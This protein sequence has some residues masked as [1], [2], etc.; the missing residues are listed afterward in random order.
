MDGIKERRLL[1][2]NNFRGLD[3]ENNPT[4]VELYRA[5]SGENFMIDSNMLKT[6]P[7]IK[8][9]FY[10]NFALEEDETLI[11]YYEYRGIKIF[12]T[13][14]HFYFDNG[15][16]VVNEQS[17]KQINGVN[18]FIKGPGLDSINFSNCVPLFQEEK[19]ALFIFCL[20]D[21]YVFS[22]FLDDNSVI[23]HYVLYDFRY[24]ISVLNYES[25]ETQYKTLLLELPFPYEPTLFIGTKVL[26]DVNLLSPVSK[27]RIFA[28][29]GYNLQEKTK[30]YFL[31][32]NYQ[33]DK[34]SSFSSEVI[35]YKDLFTDYG[36][37]PVFLGIV[38]EH[39]SALFQSDVEYTS[40]AAN[41]ENIFYP[42]QSFEYYAL[43]EGETE[44]IVIH[45]KTGLT[46]TDFFEMNVD[47]TTNKTVFEYMMGIIN[48]KNGFADDNA[49]PTNL[50][51]KFS[52]KIN[53]NCIYRDKTTYS[54]VSNI[55]EELTFNVYVQIK[56]YDK[57]SASFNNDYD[58]QSGSAWTVTNLSDSYPDYPP[59]PPP[60]E[61]K[62]YIPI[63]L[64]SIPID[65]SK[66]IIHNQT[67]VPDRV[68]SNVLFNDMTLEYINKNIG[69]F[70]D[71]DFLS[72]QCRFYVLHSNTIPEDLYIDQSDNFKITEKSSSEQPFPV[73]QNPND[74]QVIELAD[75]RVYKMFQPTLSEDNF[76]EIAR[77]IKSNMNLFTGN[78]GNAFVKIKLFLQIGN[79]YEWRSLVAPV[80]FQKEYVYTYE[81]RF[82]FIAT[83][84]ISIATVLTRDN[85]YSLSFNDVNKS[86]ELI[87]SD[88]FYDYKKEPCIDV[89]ITFSQN[90]DYN[91]ISKNKFGINFGRENRLFLA[92]H[93]NYPNIDRYNISNDLLGNNVKSQSYE[94]SYFPSK[95]YRVV[96][97]KSPINGYVVATD[98][99]LYITKEKSVN[100]TTLYIRERTIDNGGSAL[101]SEFKTSIT[102]TPVNNKC[103]VR[104]YNDII[105]LTKNG[106]YAIEISNNIL[107]NE[108]LIKLRSGFINKDLISSIANNPTVQPF[109]VENNEYMYLII[110]NTI[111]VADVRYSAT[112]ENSRAE[113][114]SYEIVKWILPMSLTFGLILNEIPSFAAS[115]SNIVYRFE[116]A[117]ED[118]K[119]IV[120]LSSA[121]VIDGSI[122]VDESLSDVYVH[123][124]KYILRINGVFQKAAKYIDDF[125]IQANPWRIIISNEPLFADIKSGDIWYN[126]KETQ[127]GVFRFLPFTIE[128]VIHDSIFSF[129]L[130]TNQRSNFGINITFHDYVYRKLDGRDLYISDVYENNGVKY[131]RVFPHEVETINK[132]S[133]LPTVFQAPELFL[134]TL[135]SG[136]QDI[137]VVEK[138]DIEMR[139][140]SAI[141]DFGNNVMEKSTFK[142]MIYATN[143]DKQSKEVKF[144]YKTMRRYSEMTSN[145]LASAPLFDF[146]ETDLSIFRLASFRATGMTFPMKEQNFLY[147]QFGVYAKGQ[148]EINAIEVIYKN[149]RMLKTIG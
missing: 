136:S 76:A 78:S 147:M 40:G 75:Y 82:S 139:W 69:D 70:E 31:P 36:V 67:P 55:N 99:L 15:E 2:L 104:F 13:N 97:S 65:S 98:S 41:I 71:G 16:Y 19:D 128:D 101:F 21:I 110:G 26:D 47:N 138:S 81:N 86:F 44:N 143:M 108:R 112:N 130:P 38:G 114:V 22:I 7:A 90:P 46:P 133:V 132:S 11:G 61:G 142:M 92:G 144:G 9:L 52:L 84:S 25:L 49:Y 73:F 94:L 3:T 34:N 29:S 105:M 50:Y 115:D 100:D 17:S 88:Y 1:A 79:Y 119:A 89:K 127:I 28:G 35:F 64:S 83:A 57:I 116:K 42:K 72:F 18:L 23:A 54:I 48:E 137:T 8:P 60:P 24:P 56:K 123:P 80:Y 146:E 145:N 4:K 131:L 43:S 45:E 96:G 102:K 113:N 12:V 95:N 66:V 129:T 30:R 87:T 74:Y 117:N 118:E 14:K 134:D 62:T 103:I 135:L 121:A 39:I 32:T 58:V 111:Y 77:Y 53:V 59:F 33:V 120:H 124:E 126:Y 109:I 68:K 93:S 107:T 10:P 20:N 141:T 63:V 125:S 6:R 37:Y 148:V 27:Y 149:N 85:K 106:L 5:S 140:V 122:V 51:V 91:L